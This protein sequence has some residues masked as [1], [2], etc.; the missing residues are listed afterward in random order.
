MNRDIEGLKRFFFLD[1]E[2]RPPILETDTVR[3]SYYRGCNDEPS[4]YVKYY[5][6]GKSYWA[7]REQLFLS[8]FFRNLQVG[9]SPKHVVLARPIH[10][11][12]SGDVIMVEMQD[13]GQSLDR[14]NNLIV[15]PPE[16]KQSLGCKVFDDTIELAKLMRWCLIALRELER[17]G[18]VH[19][20]IK[21]GN[22]C[23]P[24]DGDPLSDKGIRLRYSDLRLIDVAYSVRPKAGGDWILHEPLPIDPNP[25]TEEDR[26]AA[27]YFSAYFR[28]IL[29]NDVAGKS[30]EYGRNLN[31][32]VDMY[33]LG[34]LLREL[35]DGV[36]REQTSAFFQL[37]DEIADQWLRRYEWG[38]PKDEKADAEKNRPRHKLY[39]KKIED[40]LRKEGISEDEWE[41][42]GCWVPCQSLLPDPERLDYPPAQPNTREKDQTEK[43]VYEYKEERPTPVR[44]IPVP[45]KLPISPKGNRP[46][47]IFPS[48]SPVKKS[49]LYW[50]VS[51]LGIASL[52]VLG[53][54]LFFESN[55]PDWAVRFWHSLIDAFRSRI[56][57]SNRI[58]ASIL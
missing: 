41:I 50:V 49:A 5:K 11:A 25:E 3:V 33:A 42:S 44:K 8:Y 26:Q 48:F 52:L 7:K 36:S 15:Q 32:S 1:E 17:F 6:E 58:D 46:S 14:W 51:L 47:P 22:I 53:Y 10:S 35:L 57:F 38:L 27:T 40:L 43:P 21:A 23:V 39:L 12:A 37:L 45:A 19:C 13:A 30:P 31:Y 16:K 24:Y 54:L 20:D 9:S 29:Q 28:D 18:I 56:Q 34:R 55:V 4:H 2:T